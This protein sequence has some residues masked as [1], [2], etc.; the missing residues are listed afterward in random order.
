[1]NNIIN[2]LNNAKLTYTP[3]DIEEYY[4][5]LNQRQSEHLDK[6]KANN[7]KTWR[8]CLQDSCRSCQGTGI[9]SDGRTCYHMISCPC[10][11]CSPHYM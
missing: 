9:K 1:M 11:K 8:P 2:K 10:P 5:N 4:R 3:Q 7:T 6:V